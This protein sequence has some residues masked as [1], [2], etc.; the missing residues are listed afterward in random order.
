MG[1]AFLI[2]ASRSS[3]RGGKEGILIS[4]SLS[5][6]WCASLSGAWGGKEGISDQCFCEWCLGREG[7]HCS[8]G[9]GEK[10]LVFLPLSGRSSNKS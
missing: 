9:I 3:A 7:G 6:A 2:S 1:R 10:K 4:A 5:G 8:G